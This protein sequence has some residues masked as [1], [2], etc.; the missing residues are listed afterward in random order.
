[1]FWLHTYSMYLYSK[2]YMGFCTP[3]RT[4]MDSKKKKKKKKKNLTTNVQW[5]RSI[6]KDCW[7]CDGESRIG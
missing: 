2:C 3:K 1:M 6:P 4:I 5:K 7:K